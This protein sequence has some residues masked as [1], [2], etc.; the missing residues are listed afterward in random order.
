MNIGSRAR[1]F[2][3]VALPLLPWAIHFVAIY[4]L[5]GLVCGRGWSQP[6]GT[7]GMGA[8]TV[9]ALMAI[10][11]IGRAALRALREATGA[12]SRFVA[13][14]TLALSMLS[15]VATCFTSLPVL[16]LAPCE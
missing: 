5:Q 15:A 3:T 16:L 2:A 14:V 11:V 7:L 10:A 13:R 9:V 6:A 4:S 1:P 8:L 12:T